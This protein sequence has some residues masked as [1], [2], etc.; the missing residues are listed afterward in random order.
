MDSPDNPACANDQPDAGGGEGGVDTEAEAAAAIQASRDAALACLANGSAFPD[1]TC[2][3]NP[4]DPSCIA[5]TT[6]PYPHT[7][8]WAPAAG[9]VVLVVVISC[10]CCLCSAG[11]KFTMIDMPFWAGKI[12][13]L[14]RVESEFKPVKKRSTGNLRPLISGHLDQGPNVVAASAPEPAAEAETPATAQR[15]A[16]VT[17]TNPA[18]NRNAGVD[19]ENDYEMPVPLSPPEDDAEA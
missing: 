7:W 11:P 19:T 13:R 17:I 6:V 1:C 18:Y 2:L 4:V 3:L 9:F 16:A 12:A 8:W 15:E 10:I 14:E 5:A